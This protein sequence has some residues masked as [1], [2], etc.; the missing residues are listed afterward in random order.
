MAGFRGK[1]IKAV[2]VGDCV[3]SCYGLDCKGGSKCF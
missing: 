2:D 1:G 3:L